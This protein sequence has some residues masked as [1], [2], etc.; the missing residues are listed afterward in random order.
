MNLIQSFLFVYNNLISYLN[1]HLVSES[2]IFHIVIPSSVFLASHVPQLKKKI[3]A[4][5]V[6]TSSFATSNTIVD[7]IKSCF[8]N[9][10]II[11]QYLQLLFTRQFIYD[12]LNGLTILIE[13]SRA[14]CIYVPYPSL[15]LPP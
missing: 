6:N 8:H 3:L 9:W 1:S 15:L 11:G 12:Q 4:I 13:I 14:V 10:H 5:V 2:S 7:R